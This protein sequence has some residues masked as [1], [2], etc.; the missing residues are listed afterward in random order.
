MPKLSTRCR[1]NFHPTKTFPL[2]TTI[3]L[4]TGMTSLYIY[5]LHLLF[6]SGLGFLLNFS[7]SECWVHSRTST[8]PLRNPPPHPPCATAPPRV[9]QHGL[10]TY[11]Q[12]PR[13][14]AQPIL[15]HVLGCVYVSP[16]V[17]PGTGLT[18][19]ERRANFC[20]SIISSFWPCLDI[21]WSTPCRR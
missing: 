11:Q 1:S 8:T 2:P 5:K 14:L 12:R 17:P 6:G 18:Y 9:L 3:S 4:R 13:P 21:Q 16:S 15:G 19:R 10:S 20:S 7:S